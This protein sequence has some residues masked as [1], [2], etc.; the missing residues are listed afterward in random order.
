MAP[1]RTSGNQ[2]DVHRRR[3]RGASARSSAEPPPVPSPRPGAGPGGERPSL[4]ALSHQLGGVDLRHLAAL[5]ALARDGSLR[6]AARRLDVAPATV[7]RWIARLEATLQRQLVERGRDGA[8]LTAAGRLLAGHAQAVQT[9][10]EAARDDLDALA[11][12]ET[13]AV[14]V[15]AIAG[16]CGRLTALVV[17]ALAQ[18]RPRLHALSVDYVDEERALA[19]LAAGGVDLLLTEPPL[20]RD[21]FDCCELLL[22][23]PTLLVPTGSALAERALPLAAEDLSALTL[24]APRSAAAAERLGDAL[25]AVGARPRLVRHADEIA[26]VHALVGAG[27][28]AAIVPRLAVDPHDV[29]TVAVDLGHLLTPIPVALAWRRGDRRPA[30]VAVREAARA[31]GRE[32]TTQRALLASI[33]DDR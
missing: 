21:R 23:P 29:G 4:H 17:A 25:R 30:I 12:G 5:A 33:A 2:S 19:A 27:I 26:T 32:L 8:A 20:P 18:R 31:A 14:R 24:V 10:M 11:A 9:A 15:G 13:G 22:D 1:V 6:R 7:S 3:R 16:R 28:A